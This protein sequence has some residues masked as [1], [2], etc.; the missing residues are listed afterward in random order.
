MQNRTAAEKGIQLTGLFSSFVMFLV[1][2][3]PFKFSWIILITG[4]AMLYFATRKYKDDK[5]AGRDIDKARSIIILSSFS[6]FM[7][8]ACAIAYCFME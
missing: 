8:L 4:L 7:L 2:K 6:V 1:I 5:K 3:D